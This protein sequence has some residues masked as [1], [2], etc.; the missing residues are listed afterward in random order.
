MPR[1]GRLPVVV[2][3]FVLAVA[4]GLRVLRADQPEK[5][6]YVVGVSHLDTQWWWTI[7]ET[8][9]TCLP[10][11]FSGTFALFDKYPHFNFS[12]EGAFRYML[13]EEYY[14]DLYQELLDWAAKGRWAPAGSSF[15]AG[16]V[17]IVSP[18][19]LNRHFLYGNRYFGESLGRRSADVFLPDCFGFGWALPSVAAHCGLTGFSTQKLGWGSA[20]E[21]PY[22]IGRWSGP[23]G[24]TLTAVLN[25]GSYIATINGDLSLDEELFGQCS[26]ELP[27]DD[28]AVSYHYF[29]TGDQGGPVPDDSA[30][31]VDSSV[32]GAGPIEVVSASSDQLFRDLTPA[33]AASLPAYTGELLLSTHGTGC[34]TSQAAM[35]RFNR[36]NEQLAQAAEA[37]A[38][39]A[40]WLGGL[41]YPRSEIHGAWVR[42]LS[43]H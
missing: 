11:T 35:K 15:E 31:W 24:G 9:R 34:Y 1:R 40:D 42:F 4:G 25:P 19:S 36:R 14:P 26:A 22:T 30:A 3:C 7:Q 5:K 28:L 20:I 17:N 2:L 23:D 27:G 33:Q 29:G 32:A 39:A 12:W 6:L 16:D 37:A 8:I 38:V 10:A 13:L 41:A 43:R 21:L 18:E